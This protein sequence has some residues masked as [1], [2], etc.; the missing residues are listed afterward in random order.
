MEIT[1]GHGPDGDK[2]WGVEVQVLSEG[3]AKQPW[4]TIGVGICSCIVI[5]GV[6]EGWR[7]ATR[8]CS[9]GGVMAP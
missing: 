8:D 6:V 5:T 7:E 4:L 2:G 3:G 9:V 1:S